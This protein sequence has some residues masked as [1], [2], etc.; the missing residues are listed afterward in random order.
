MSKMNREISAMNA[1][2]KDLRKAKK[3][4]SK[5]EESHMFKI[6]LVTN[7]EVVK[8]RSKKSRPTR[9]PHWAPLYVD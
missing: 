5:D 2:L 8:R 4:S 9:L 6:M 7:L 3:T 1:K